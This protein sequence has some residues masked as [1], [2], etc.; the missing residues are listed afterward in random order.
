MQATEE[1]LAPFVG[2]YTRPFTDIYL[3]LLGGRLIGQVI[4]KMGFPAKDSPI[5]PPP[6]PFTLD[7]VEKD[8]LMVLHGPNKSAKADIIRNTDGSIGW[9]RFG[10]IHKKVS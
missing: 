7:L 5:P 2:E 4:Y 10:R 6:P 9:L 8:R 3:G 1:Q